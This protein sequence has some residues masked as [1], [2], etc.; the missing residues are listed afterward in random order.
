[1]AA[2]TG[3]APSHAEGRRLMQP[4]HLNHRSVTD[5]ALYAVR[6]VRV[7]IEEH[8]SRKT[9]D[10]HPWDRFMPVPVAVKPLDLPVLRYDD[11]VAAHAELRLGH[12]GK[13]RCPH[14]AMA[15]LTRDALIS[16]MHPVEEI[17]RLPRRA[18]RF[19]AVG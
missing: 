10:P 14:R 15:E 18:V 19:E 13:R 17:D 2:M 4:V 3:H 8:E 12:P 11:P 16:G 6:H 9:V 1:M 7:V 5:R